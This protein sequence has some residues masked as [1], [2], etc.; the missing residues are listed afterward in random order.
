MAYEASSVEV[1]REFKGRGGHC[2]FS[3]ESQERQQRGRGKGD[4][5]KL[6]VSQVPTGQEGRHLGLQKVVIRRICLGVCL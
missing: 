5:G 1:Q 4:T 2:L 6:E 3:L